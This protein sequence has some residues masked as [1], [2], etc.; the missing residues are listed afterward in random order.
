LAELAVRS[1]TGLTV[2]GV[3]GHG[4]LF[5]EA[6]SRVV[7][8]VAPDRVTAVTTAAEEAGVAWRSLGEVGGER[9]IVDGLVDLGLA[10][11]VERWRGTIPLALHPDD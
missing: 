4:E 3:D 9:F 5:S 7:V 2:E 11:M 10:G 1:R 8:S 6:P